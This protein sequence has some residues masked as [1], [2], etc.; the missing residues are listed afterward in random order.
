MSGTWQ[1]TSCLFCGLSEG[2]QL[3]ELISFDDST[4][5]HKCGLERE[6]THQEFVPKQEAVV[7]LG[8][9]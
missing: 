1:T 3:S 4:K 6:M 9:V 5:K 8:D 7:R 2:L